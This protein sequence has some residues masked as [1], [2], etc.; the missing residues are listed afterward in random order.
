MNLR[1]AARGK[2]CVLCWSFN[3]VVLHHLQV[4]GNHGTGRKPDDFPWGVRL[5]SKCHEHFHNDGRSDHKGMLQAM[6]NQLLAY[7]EEGV[8]K[9]V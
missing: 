9:V 4:P 6:G 7:L 1:A 5:C 3:G 8:V 2:P